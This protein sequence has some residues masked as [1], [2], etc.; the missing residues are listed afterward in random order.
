MSSSGCQAGRSDNGR[1]PVT[2]R[3]WT[4]VVKHTFMLKENA[5]KTKKIVIL[6]IS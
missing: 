2:Q 5:R 1:N 3:N 6:S 4:Q